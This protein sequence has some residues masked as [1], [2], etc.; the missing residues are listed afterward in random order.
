MSDSADTTTLAVSLIQSAHSDY[1]DRWKLPSIQNKTREERWQFID[2]QERLIYSLVNKYYPTSYVPGWFHR[3]SATVQCKY[4][5]LFHHPTKYDHQRCYGGGKNN[6]Q[7]DEEGKKD[8]FSYL[9]I[10]YH[11]LEGAPSHEEAE[12]AKDDQNVHWPSTLLQD[13]YVS[14]LHPFFMPFGKEEVSRQIE[15]ATS[16]LFGT[17]IKQKALVAGIK[18]VIAIGAPMIR[19]FF[20]FV[21]AVEDDREIKSKYS[22][23]PFVFTLRS[24]DKKQKISRISC[25]L[26]Y[27]P[28]PWAFLRGQQ[29]L[30]KEL[31]NLS[32]DERSNK[33]AI[34]QHEEQ[35]FDDVLKSIYTFIN[36][37][38]RFKKAVPIV[39]EETGKEMLDVSKTIRL[40]I[41]EKTKQDHVKKEK[42]RKEKEA[43]AKKKKV[44]ADMIK[45]RRVVATTTEEVK[46]DKQEGEKNAFDALKEGAKTLKKVIIHQQK[47][48]KQPV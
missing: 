19:G 18:L 14:F 20:R 39:D 40:G 12:A 47:K 13:Y 34:R 5:I 32:I 35:M 24:E 11:L 26:L 7:E 46:K 33:M 15:N 6:G 45:S 37:L 38:S 27:C 3:P 44:R 28:H 2:Q 4:M 9:K 1:M 8:Y 29:D 43:E 23:S 22:K 48:E 25:A 16:R 30:F 36:P 21:R 31:V 41:K 10:F 17:Y 42:K